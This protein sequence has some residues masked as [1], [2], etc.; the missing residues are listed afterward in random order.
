MFINLKNVGV[1]GFNGYSSCLKCTTD[2]EYSYQSNTMIFPE[3]KAPLRN[4]SDFRAGKYEGHYKKRTIIENIKGLDMIKHFPIGDALHLI[5]LGI[6]KRYLQ[7]FMHG[8]LNNFNSK[9]SSQEINQISNFLTN[10]TLPIE[11]NRQL[12]GLDEIKFWKATEFRSFLCYIS[13]IVMR[14]FFKDDIYYHFMNF[15][16]AIIICSMHHQPIHN[17]N[18]AQCMIDDFLDGIKILYGRS[19][20]TSNIHNLCHLVDDVKQFG[21]LHTFTAYTSESKLFQIKRLVR[22]GNLPLSQ[23]ARRITEIQQNLPNDIAKKNKK[24]SIV[25]RKKIYDRTNVSDM[26]RMFLSQSS[27]AYDLY[28]F[29]RL[30]KFS[31]NVLRDSD[32]WILVKFNN[33]FQIFCIHYI[34]HDPQNNVIKL[35]GRK[36]HTLRHLFSKPVISSNLQIYSANLQFEDRCKVI[37]LENVHAKMVKIVHDPFNTANN[38]FAFFPLIHTLK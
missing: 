22:T 35:F 2:G 8:T 9:L 23:V 12:R 27:T 5:D 4:N 11:F 29:V 10:C 25:F 19:L 38:T 28:N 17:Y 26:M 36:L 1:I 30:E 7:G 13:P 6:T 21:P 33:E 3:T 32:K 37:N 18:I 20:F 24:L 15:F 16:C 31:I 34:M 14:A